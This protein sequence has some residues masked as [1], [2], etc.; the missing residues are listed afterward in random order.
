M[1]TN[2]QNP[3][4]NIGEIMNK[5]IAFIEEF[6]NFEYLNNLN[7]TTNEFKRLYLDIKKSNIYNEFIYIS[8][9]RS[10]SIVFFD[11]NRYVQ[12][13]IYNEEDE[14]KRDDLI[15]LDKNKNFNVSQWLRTYNYLDYKNL[16]YIDNDLEDIDKIRENFKKL[17]KNIEK[18]FEIKKINDILKGEDWDD[19]P[20]EFLLYK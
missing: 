12:V 20:D 19:L 11:N 17:K 4:I 7:Y 5:V 1:A 9:K 2:Y 16:L 18:I 13:W 6:E 10:V 15:Y 8:K 3:N 14:Y